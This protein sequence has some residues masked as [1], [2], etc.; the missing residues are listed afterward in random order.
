MFTIHLAPG[1]RWSH[2]LL[3]IVLVAL[4]ADGSSAQLPNPDGTLH[5]LVVSSPD[6]E[7][8]VPCATNVARVC[9]LFSAVPQTS[10]TVLPEV[11]VTTA[12][13]EQAISA[14]SISE[15]DALLIYYT[16]HGE[17]T[18][19]DQQLVIG[20]QRMQRSTLLAAARGKKARLTCLIT[21]ACFIYAKLSID[22]G[23][24]RTSCESMERIPPLF[25]HLF[26]KCHGVVDL[27]ACAPGQVSTTY[28]MISRGSIFTH[29][30]V[31]ELL[32]SQRLLDW[33][34]FVKLVS[35]ETAREYRLVWPTGQEVPQFNRKPTVIQEEQRPTLLTPLAVTYEAMP[36]VLPG[37]PVRRQFYEIDRVTGEVFEVV[38]EERRATPLS[39]PEYVEVERKSLAVVADRVV[40]LDGAVAFHF[41]GAVIVVS[42]PV[43]VLGLA[44]PVPLGATLANTTHGVAVVEVKAGSPASYGRD[45]STG[46]TTPLQPGDIL[47]AVNG[48]PVTSVHQAHELL[49]TSVTT[50]ELQVQRAVELPSLVL[51]TRLRDDNAAGAIRDAGTTIRLL[52]R[53]AQPRRPTLEV[54]LT[55]VGEQF[56]ICPV[57]D[58]ESPIEPGQTRDCQIGPADGFAVASRRNGIPQIL[59]RVVEFDETTREPG[60]AWGK[61]DG[62]GK[63]LG[64]PYRESNI[65]DRSAQTISRLISIE[66]TD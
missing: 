22:G 58:D 59:I 23:E 65:V 5:V 18:D 63:P 42:A 64:L 44:P 6:D 35:D 28:A 37:P 50:A 49:A 53:T 36:P 12:A 31:S 62:D 29:A 30:L 24:E 43:V 54:W 55:K 13:I 25:A 32:N 1:Q 9:Q 4:W 60:R 21:E 27:N 51:E 46:E 7:I 19:G 15:N 16:G 26:W 66:I 34:E 41:G 40:S 61:V 57:F 39:E 45:V 14:L 56:G 10:V 38:G 2:A 17:S 48:E 20:G 3:I 52:N 11:G 47:Q 8:A 33:D